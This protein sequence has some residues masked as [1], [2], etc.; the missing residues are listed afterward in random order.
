MY[1]RGNTRIK[2]DAYELGSSAPVR[3][4]GDETLL[5]GLVAQVPSGIGREQE[6][7]QWSPAIHVIDCRHWSFARRHSSGASSG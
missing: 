2:C 3:E 4:V 6:D 5:N 1:G 7:F